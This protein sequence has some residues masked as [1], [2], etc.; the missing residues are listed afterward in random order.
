[1]NESISTITHQTV[2]FSPL[3]WGLG[4]VSRS[5]P[6]L[7]QLIEQGNEIIV[8]CNLDQEDF[9][10][11]Y[12]PELWYVSHKGYP[13]KF[14]G[15]GSFMKDV[16]VNYFQLKHRLDVELE[17]VKALVKVFTPDIIISD[18]RFGFR[19][20]KVK[21]V[22]IS[23]QLRLNLPKYAF[24]GQWIN[25]RFLKKFDEVWVPDDELNLSGDLS[26]SKLAHKRIGILSRFQHEVETQA[27]KYKYLVIVSGPMPY[28]KDF[29]LEMSERLSVCEG[30]HAVIAGLDA[31]DYEATKD[32]VDVYY[33]PNQEWMERLFGEAEIVISRSGYSTLMDLIRLKRKAILIP[34]KGQSE[35]EYLAKHNA[36]RKQFTFVTEEE[37]KNYPL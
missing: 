2:L 8:C 7:K 11:A 37:F 32:N 26:V 24:L 31:F 16:F 6:L 27:V 28:A 25:K 3:N 13:F 17:E 10:R 14:E 5:V 15:K 23:H 22:I 12:F 33:Q 1:M 19:H 9:Y 34:T 29:L 36:Q 21:S 18:Q 4:H 30:K 20:R 35:Q